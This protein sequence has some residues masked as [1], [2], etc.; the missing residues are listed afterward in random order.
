MSGYWQTF[1]GDVDEKPPRPA[2]VKAQHAQRGA[3]HMEKHLA[4]ERIEHQANLSFGKAFL[5][6]LSARAQRIQ[7]VWLHYGNPYL[8]DIAQG[9]VKG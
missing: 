8:G 4:Q 6:A 7:D 5:V 3:T 1:E 2:Q 9:L